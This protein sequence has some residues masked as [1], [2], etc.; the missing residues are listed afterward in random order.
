MK[1]LMISVGVKAGVGD[2]VRD[3]VAARNGPI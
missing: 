3:A 1:T 2:R